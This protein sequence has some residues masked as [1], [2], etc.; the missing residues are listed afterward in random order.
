VPGFLVW[1]RC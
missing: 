1:V